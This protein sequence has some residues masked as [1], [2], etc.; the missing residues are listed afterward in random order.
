MVAGENNIRVT[1]SKTN[2][3]HSAVICTT[4]RLLL[5]LSSPESHS[6]GKDI[7]SHKGLHKVAQSKNVLDSGGGGGS[8]SSSSSSSGGGGCRRRHCY[9][10]CRCFYS[11]I[12]FVKLHIYFQAQFH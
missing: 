7:E 8:S 9:C 4:F 3:Q 11:F 12:R 10:Y 2:T 5:L 6:T 1:E